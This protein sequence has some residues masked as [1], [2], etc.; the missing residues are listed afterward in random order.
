MRYSIETHNLQYGYSKKNAV[1]ADINLQVPTGSIF[2]FLGKN[3]AGKTTTIKLLLGLIKLQEGSV[4]IFDKSIHTH[5]IEI[6]QEVGSLIE[7]PSFYP[8]LSAYDNLLIQQQLFQCSSSRIKEIIELVGLTHAEKKKVGKYSLGMKQRLGIGMALL[9]SPKLLI[10]DEPTNGLDPE[11]IIEIRELL[12]T[13]NQQLGTTILIS[14]HLLAE[15]EKLVDHVA[16][17]DQGTILFQGTLKALQERQQEKSSCI[18]KTNDLHKT[19]SLFRSKSIHH[20]LNEDHIELSSL[21]KD[22][23]AS[24]IQLL[25][26]HNIAVYQCAPVSTDLES[27]FMNLTHQS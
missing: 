24:T 5:R 16:I 17:I 4:S 9:H 26:E 2:G 20:Q 21:E 12:K 11:G 15:I 3:G 22:S 25:V 10:L 23:I 7:S 27:I 18:L 13:I 1:L 19:S 6:L 14:S 8:H